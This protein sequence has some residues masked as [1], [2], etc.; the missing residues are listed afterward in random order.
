MRT[1]YEDFYKIH[2]CAKDKC[3]CNNKDCSC[4]KNKEKCDMLQE[5]L[6]FEISDCNDCVIENVGMAQAYIPF[7]TEFNPMEPCCSLMYGTVFPCLVQPYNKK[8]CNNCAKG[9]R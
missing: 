5:E 7:Q 9:G 2:G 6:C 3:S 8:C 4:G 1:V